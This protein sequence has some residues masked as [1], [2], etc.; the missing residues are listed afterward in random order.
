MKLMLYNRIIYSRNNFPIAMQAGNS[1]K[2]KIL[3]VNRLA[4]MNLLLRM[5]KKGVKNIKRNTQGKSLLKKIH[6]KVL[7]YNPNKM[8]II[9]IKIILTTI[10]K[11]SNIILK[12]QF[13]LTFKMNLMLKKSL[14][15]ISLKIIF[16][17]S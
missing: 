1:A 13:K 6:N 17:I 14:L 9:Q 12:A 4:E 8:K 11:E 10:N 5:K 7:F 2:E 3:L 16:H 15:T